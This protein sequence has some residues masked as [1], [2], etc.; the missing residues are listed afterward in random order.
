MSDDTKSTV[1]LG[2]VGQLALALASAQGKFPAIKKSHVVKVEIKTGGSY[3]YNYADLADVL[4]AVRPILS[5]EG[6]AI[7]QPIVW[8]SEPLLITLLVHASGEW[9]ESVYRLGEY[10]KPQEM[11][12]AITYA[13]RY[14]LTS[15]LGIAAEDDDDGQ[16]AQQGTSKV[17]RGKANKACPACGVEGSIIKGKEEFGGGWVCWKKQGGCGRNFAVTDPHFATEQP[18]E[19]NAFDREEEPSEPKRMNPPRSFDVQS[20]RSLGDELLRLTGDKEAAA[21][22]LSEITADNSTTTRG[23]SPTATEA[24]WTRLAAHPVYGL[25]KEQE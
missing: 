8:H 25:P 1:T 24:A 12:S 10:D 16:R 6:L 20:R 19:E 15:M 13:R 14:A 18:K 11:G 2:N 21:K 7:L 17:A 22:L 5:A 3:E 9:I 23:L 4:A